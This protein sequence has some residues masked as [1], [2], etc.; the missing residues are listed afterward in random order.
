M[1]KTCSQLAEEMLV[2]R[3]T[4]YRAVEDG[5][6]ASVSAGRLKRISEEEFARV[7]REGI[8]AASETLDRR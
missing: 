2:S 7:K 4:V 8:P 6:I 3:S 5:R 1:M